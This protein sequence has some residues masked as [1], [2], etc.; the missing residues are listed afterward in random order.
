MKHYQPVRIIYID[1]SV[2]HVRIEFS[3]KIFL[4]AFPRAGLQGVKWTPNPYIV[5]KA[6][7]KKKETNTRKLKK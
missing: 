3:R 7:K 6:Q 4:F 1:L 2:A 5:N